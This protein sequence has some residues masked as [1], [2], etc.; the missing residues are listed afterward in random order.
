MLC[1]YITNIAGCIVTNV[2]SLHLLSRIQ[3]TE[4]CDGVEDGQYYR[5]NYTVDNFV[6]Y[7]CRR[8]IIRVIKFDIP[9]LVAVLSSLIVLLTCCAR[10]A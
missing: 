4:L 8:K 3:F 2:A 1:V 5:A 7:Y 9:K 10:N 6:F